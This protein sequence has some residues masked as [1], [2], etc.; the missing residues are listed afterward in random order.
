MI[1]QAW[2]IAVLGSKK[3]ENHIHMV[4]LYT[5]WYN[6]V[7]INSAVK[8]SPAMAAGLSQTLWEMD[9]LVAM[10]DAYENSAKVKL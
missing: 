10:V 7:R 2:Q 8:T 5:V 1:H 3:L 6:Y 9:D 4:S